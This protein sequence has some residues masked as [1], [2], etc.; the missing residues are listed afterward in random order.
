MHADKIIRSFIIAC[1]LVMSSIL[2]AQAD[3]YVF[4]TIDVPSTPATGTVSGTLAF[5]VTNPVAGITGP[6]M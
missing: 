3:P 6:R 1:G 5:N 4:S 2:S